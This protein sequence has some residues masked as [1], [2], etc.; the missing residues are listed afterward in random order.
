MSRAP[1][2]SM[3]P[4][5]TVPLMDGRVQDLHAAAG[6]NGATNNANAK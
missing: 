5:T 3:A 4:A 1:T 6:R 2:A